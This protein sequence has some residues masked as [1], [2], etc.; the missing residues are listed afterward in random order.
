MPAQIPISMSALTALSFIETQT[1]EP[2]SAT[3][4]LLVGA[5]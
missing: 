2:E 1:G 4:H 5:A 3:E